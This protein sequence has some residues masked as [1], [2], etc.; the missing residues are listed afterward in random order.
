M[1]SVCQGSNFTPCDLT[2][3][4]YVNSEYIWYNGQTEENCSIYLQLNYFN[5]N[6]QFP[7]TN[8]DIDVIRYKTNRTWDSVS[9]SI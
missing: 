6:I 7:Q 3:E 5:W 2:L 1:F 4:K 9:L 8:I